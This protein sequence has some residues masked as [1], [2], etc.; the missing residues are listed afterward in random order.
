M[1]C[2]GRGTKIRFIHYRETLY[3]LLVV[4]SEEEVKC[5]V[6]SK[7]NQS[8]MGKCRMLYSLLIDANKTCL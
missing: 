1:D 5:R 3:R 8:I 7:L 6:L 4:K 2:Q